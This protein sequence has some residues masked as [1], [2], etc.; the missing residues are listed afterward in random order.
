MAST[1][2]METDGDGRYYDSDASCVAALK[3]RILSHDGEKP[4]CAFLGLLA[5]HPPYGVE[6]PYFQ[7]IDRNRLPKRVKISD[8][9]NKSDML[10][11]LRALYGMKDWTEDRFDELR[12]TYL[13]MCMKVDAFYGEIVSALKTAGM[14]E[15]TLLVFLSDHGDY[16]GDYDVVEKAQNTFEDCIT[17][18]PLLIKPPKWARVSPGTTPA[19]TELVDFYATVLDYGQ[20]QA[21][22]THFGNS[23]R[24]V[25]ENRHVENRTFVCCE[26]G[27]RRDEAHCNSAAKN[28]GPENPY[29]PRFQMQGRDACVKGTMIRDRQFKYIYR[30]EGQDELYDLIKDPKEVENL[31]GREAYAEE[32]LQR[33][34]KLLSWYQS[35]CDLVPQKPDQRMNTAMQLSKLSTRLP[36]ETLTKVK[37]RV[38]AGESLE[39]VLQALT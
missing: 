34:M 12:A 17:N 32:V 35:T 3:R 30:A 37:T 18:V 5:P 8:D 39:A 21:P 14:Y 7:S 31:A 1:R 9:A 16:T 10:M 36:P 25:I 38:G 2:S 26:G 20:L 28:A 27:R 22:E 29:Y 15:D 11:G 19:L 4:L 24:P 6:A 13:G 23:L 33:K